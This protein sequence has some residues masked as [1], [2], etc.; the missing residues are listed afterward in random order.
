MSDQKPW[1]REYDALIA[2]RAEGLHPGKKT[3]SG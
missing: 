2:E 1:L 3:A